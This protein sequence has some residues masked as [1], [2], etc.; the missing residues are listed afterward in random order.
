MPIRTVVEHLQILKT[1]KVFAPKGVRVNGSISPF[2]SAWSTIPETL[3]IG[4][5]GLKDREPLKVSSL[6]G[7]KFSIYQ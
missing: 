7:R 6:R 5:L 1:I 2:L 3:T 4:G